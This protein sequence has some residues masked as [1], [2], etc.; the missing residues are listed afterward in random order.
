MDFTTE[1]RAVLAGCCAKKLVDANN[2]PPIDNSISPIPGDLVW[3]EVD[4]GVAVL[5]YSVLPGSALCHYTS[6]EG[7]EYN[8]EGDV[9]ALEIIGKCVFGVYR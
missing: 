5:L 4:G 3:G 9:K 8:R 2:I 6:Q 7:K 1:E